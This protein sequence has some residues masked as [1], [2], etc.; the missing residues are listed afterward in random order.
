MKIDVI[1]KGEGI[2]DKELNHIFEPLFVGK[3]HIVLK[4]GNGLGLTIAKSNIELLNGKIIIN[5]HEN[6]GT[7]VTIL[8]KKKESKI[9]L[10]FIYY[11]A[12][13]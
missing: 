12:H 8:I 11:F 6:E 9:T 4:S 13:L 10:L 7:I 2:S 5:T 1:D 3:K